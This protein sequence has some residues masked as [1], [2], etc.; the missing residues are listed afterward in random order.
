MEKGTHR[1]SA[2][3][4]V[5][6]VSWHISVAVF[7]IV[8]AEFQYSEHVLNSVLISSSTVYFTFSRIYQTF[9]ADRVDSVGCAN[10]KENK[11]KLEC[12]AFYYYQ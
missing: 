6:F 1:Y 7:Q 9:M 3:I 10:T 4:S 12:H 11:Q 8:Y 5:R 2:T